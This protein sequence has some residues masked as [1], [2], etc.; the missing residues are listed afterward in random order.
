[1]TCPHPEK[2]AHRSLPAAFEHLRSLED[3]EKGDGETWPYRCDGCG[4][5]HLGHPRKKGAKKR[6]AE[7]YAIYLRDHP[8][9]AARPAPYTKDQRT[10]NRR[11]KGALKRGRR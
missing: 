11:I 5:F 2:R 1:M 7:M 9:P 8:L 4:H 3:H 6:M 10:I